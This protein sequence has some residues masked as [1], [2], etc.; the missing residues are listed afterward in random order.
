MRQTW[1]IDKNKQGGK[2][3]GRKGGHELQ[4]FSERTSE[5]M[6]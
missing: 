6:E 2:G 1:K 3:Q 4:S 5:Y